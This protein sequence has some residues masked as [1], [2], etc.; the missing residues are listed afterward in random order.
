[1]VLHEVSINILPLPLYQGK[2]RAS[3]G[4]FLESSVADPDAG[5]G[6]FFTPGSGMNIQEHFSEGIETVFCVSR[7]QSKGYFLESPKLSVYGSYMIIRVVIRIPVDQI[8]LKTPNPK[9]C[10]L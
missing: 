10:R 8:S 3:K 9:K 1:M 4:Y 2:E 5:S 7:K 6:V